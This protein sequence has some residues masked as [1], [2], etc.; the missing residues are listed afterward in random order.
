MEAGPSPLGGRERRGG[1]QKER[2][3]ASQVG[4]G[5]VFRVLQVHARMNVSKVWLLVLLLGLAQLAIL[6]RCQEEEQGG[7]ECVI[8][9][10][11]VDEFD[12]GLK[13]KWACARRLWTAKFKGG[14]ICKGITTKSAVPWEDTVPQM[15]EVSC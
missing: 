14:G 12:S 13:M 5:V 6:A 4:E 11:V 7:G 9:S 10:A 8:S 3:K 15:L 2:R 1:K